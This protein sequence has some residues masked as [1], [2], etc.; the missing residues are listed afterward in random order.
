MLRNSA[1]PF[2]KFEIWIKSKIGSFNSNQNV[3][4][5]IKSFDIIYSQPQLFSFT[6]TKHA[7]AHA[8]AHLAKQK[9]SKYITH[10]PHKK[11]ENG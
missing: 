11:H 9:Y 3:W 1:I 5:E 10:S 2:H 8:K 7:H 6:R 4:K